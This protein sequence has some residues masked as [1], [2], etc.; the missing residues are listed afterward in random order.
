MKPKLRMQVRWAWISSWQFSSPFSKIHWSR[1]F[2][3]SGQAQ[4]GFNGFPSFP[5]GSTPECVE[6]VFTVS[7]ICKSAIKK[8]EGFCH[9]TNYWEHHLSSDRD[10][11][12]G[13]FL[14]AKSSHCVRGQICLSFLKA[15]VGLNKWVY[16]H[17]NERLWCACFYS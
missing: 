13:L 5:I 4:H 14:L 2:L 8:D 12:L 3:V 1:T 11:A 10:G 17:D 7:V 15:M 6:V 16:I 9:I